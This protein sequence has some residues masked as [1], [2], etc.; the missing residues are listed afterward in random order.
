VLCKFF[1][2]CHSCMYSLWEFLPHDQQMSCP[3]C[4]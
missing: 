3:F 4:L 2:N 1:H